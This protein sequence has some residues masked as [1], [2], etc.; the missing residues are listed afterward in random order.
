MTVTITQATQEVVAG[1]T[2]TMTVAWMSDLPAGTG[3]SSGIQWGDGSGGPIFVNGPSG[4]VTISYTYTSSGVDNVSV[5]V[6][7]FG[8]GGSAAG[9]AS[10]T[11]TVTAPPPSDPVPDICSCTCTGGT[12]INNAPGAAGPPVPMVSSNPVR[13]A[14]GVVQIGAADLSSDGF[15]VPWGQSRSWTNGP[16]YAAGGDN[17]NGWV[18]AQTPRLLQADGSTNTTIVAVSNGTTARYFDLVSGA[19]KPRFFDKSALVHNAASDEFVLTDES[20]DQLHFADFNSAVP[21][22]EQGVLKSFVDPYGNVTAVTSWTPSGQPAE[23]QRST[24]SGGNTITESYLYAYLPAGTNGGLLQSV[25]LR[26]Q[27]NGG[28]WSTVR[29][30]QYTYYDGVQPY[31]NLGDLQLAQVLDGSGDVLD[32]CYYRYYTPADAGSTGY[33]GGLKYAF[34]PESYARL[35]TALGSTAPTAATDSQVSAYADNYFEY[36]S[37]RRATKEIAQGAGCSTC[38]G[39]L[40]TFTYSYTSSG[41]A[42]GFNSW[43]TKTVETLPDGN[44]NTVYTNAYGEEMLLVYHDASSGLNWETFTKYDGQGQVALEADPSAVTGYND[45][46]ADLLNSQNGLY[47]YLSDASGQITLFDY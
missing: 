44:Q 9:S 39:G 11:V 4:S 23:V 38:S 16:G 34:G 18:D 7:L 36:D 47:Q 14:D 45:A 1:G 21:P 6:G 43:A 17:G 5:G 26:R 28:A 35:V 42:A 27:T 10:G 15:G 3:G 22:A 46:Y 13:Y 30:V 12:L 40:G 33:V 8:A 31:G 2:V 32:T 19:Y 20:G 29:Q 41:N 25:T 37:S 24:V